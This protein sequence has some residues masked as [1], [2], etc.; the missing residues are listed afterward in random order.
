M[1][2]GVRGLCIAR[3]DVRIRVMA[4]PILCLCVS[5]HSLVV[6]RELSFSWLETSVLCTLLAMCRFVC[7]SDVVVV[8][9]I[10]SMNWLVSLG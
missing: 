5:V 3:W 10:V 6:I 8:M 2:A 7:G 4:S 1:L 9:N